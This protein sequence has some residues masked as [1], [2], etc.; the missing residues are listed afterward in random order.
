MKWWNV[1]EEV[2]EAVTPQGEL[3]LPCTRVPSLRWKDLE[4]LGAPWLNVGQGSS[5]ILGRGS[6][7]EEAGCESF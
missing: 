3:L 1:N 5:P 2:S 7:G 4:G 6:L